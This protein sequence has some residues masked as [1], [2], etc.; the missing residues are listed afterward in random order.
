MNIK[1]KCVGHMYV[2]IQKPCSYIQYFK[3][4]VGQKL[5]LQEDIITNA[6]HGNY[7]NDKLKLNPVGLFHFNCDYKTSYQNQNKIF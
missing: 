6:G 1:E 7:D 2:Q 4:I 3:T 5:Q